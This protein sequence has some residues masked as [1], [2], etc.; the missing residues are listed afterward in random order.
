MGW[1][2]V[3]SPGRD[4]ENHVICPKIKIRQEEGQKTLM[5]TKKRIPKCV[6][7]CKRLGP[8]HRA[9][10]GDGGGMYWSAPNIGSCSEWCTRQ[11]WGFVRMP[12]RVP[13][14]Q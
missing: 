10:N 1:G 11:D 4:A 2:G 8:I 7:G 12:S 6:K 3:G 9:C 14:L 13:R 5:S